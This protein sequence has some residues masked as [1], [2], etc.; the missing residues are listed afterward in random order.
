MNDSAPEK[1]EKWTNRPGTG[2][3]ATRRLGSSG[4]AEDQATLQVE[5]FR[6]KELGLAKVPL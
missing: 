2:E 3:S 1:P 4:R 6:V 5:P